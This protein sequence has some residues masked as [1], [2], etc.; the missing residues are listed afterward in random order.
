[1]P[2]ERALAVQPRAHLSNSLTDG[3]QWADGSQLSDGS[4]L[5]EAR[6]RGARLAP[7]RRVCERGMVTAEYAVGILAA[8]ALALVLVQ[9]F[10]DDA[11]SAELLRQVTKLI[12]QLGASIK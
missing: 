11:F 2:L 9:V 3:S 4:Q 5:P 8:I 10:Q 7:V 12:G 6:A 1:M